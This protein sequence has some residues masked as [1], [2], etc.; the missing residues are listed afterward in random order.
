MAMA[1]TAAQTPPST[2]AVSVGA[3]GKEIGIG[4][5]ALVSLLMVSAIVR[6][7]SAAPAGAQRGEGRADHLAE[8]EIAGVVP[9]SDGMLDDMELDE[10]AIRAQ[11]IR[12]QVQTMVKD[13]PDAAA[14]LVN[15]WL[16]RT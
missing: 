11:Q 7:G 13:N 16:S 4:A 8:E 1:A 14:N 5:L 3:Y 9:D 2:I 6:K 10:D 15:R 12:Q